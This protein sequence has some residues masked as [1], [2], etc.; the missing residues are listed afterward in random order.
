M[1]SSDIRIGLR[2]I[3][4]IH[5]NLS[6]NLKSSL[7]VVWCSYRTNFQRCLK[8]EQDRNPTLVLVTWNGT[9]EPFPTGVSFSA[10][11]AGIRFL[12]EGWL[13]R[14]EDRQSCT[15]SFRAFSCD[16]W[17]KEEIISSLRCII[18]NRIACFLPLH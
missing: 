13:C 12:A 17:G 6:M 7:V 15:V 8:K 3:F 16:S 11:F 5:P 4:K 9:F 1:K 2:I 14:T 10:G 18:M